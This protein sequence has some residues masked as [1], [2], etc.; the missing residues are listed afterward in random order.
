MVN[1]NLGD[2]MVGNC[3]AR[4]ADEEAAQRAIVGLN[5][6]FYGGR[7]LIAEFSPVTDF[8]E[9]RCRQ[10]DE[11]SCNRG[12]Y[13]NFM[14]LKH[15]PRAHMKV[16]VVACGVWARTQRVCAFTYVS[17]CARLRARVRV[18]LCAR[19]CF[20]VWVRA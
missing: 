20:S 9:A 18:Y 17:V 19:P 14:H 16:C 11:T 4:Y 2:H 1:D 15:V 5:G 12:G 3:F 13:C 10:F 8:R 6:R 7:P